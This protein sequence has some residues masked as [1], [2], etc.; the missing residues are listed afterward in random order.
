M[1]FY[2]Q[3]PCY[4]KY[5]AKAIKGFEANLHFWEML[6]ILLAR[7]DVTGYPEHIPPEYVETMLIFN[8][9]VGFGRSSSDDKIWAVAG[10]YHGN[11]IG[12]LP[13]SYQ[14][15]LPGINTIDGKVN[16]EIIVGWNNALRTPDFD[17]QQYTSILTEIDVS[18]RLNVIFSRFLRIPKV[19]DSKEK[20]TVEES[21]NN[22]IDGKISA[23]VINDI[24]KQLLGDATG[25][26]F[27]DLVDIKEVDKLQYLNQYRE[28]VVKR[29][30]QRYGQGVNSTSKLAQQTIEELHGTDAISMIYTLQCLKYR[31]KMASE[32]NNKFGW[33]VEYKLSECWQDSYD[34][35]IKEKTGDDENADSNDT[36]DETPGDNSGDADTDN[37][38]TVD[39]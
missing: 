27:L 10:G 32:L 33:S 4:D 9:T 3:M 15:T 28:N 37:T 30:Y 18:E 6:Q 26:D 17:L 20:K 35:A 38:S 36:R 23:V 5:K 12:Y 39:D 14:G 16:D 1:N 2:K 22:L 13:D 8:G 34:E 11:V 21:I 24:G 19:R 7:F 29:F 31:Q 25:I